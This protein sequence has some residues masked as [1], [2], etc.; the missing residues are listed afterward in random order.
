MVHPDHPVMPHWCESPQVPV[1]YDR[2][3]FAARRYLAVELRRPGDH[4]C[5]G[6][7]GTGPNT[8]LK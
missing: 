1:V 3:S 6:W 7:P 5:C 2:G 4:E 8:S